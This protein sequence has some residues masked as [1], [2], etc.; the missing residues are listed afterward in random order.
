MP[1]GKPAGVTCVNLDPQTH[2]CTIWG[3]EKYPEVCR[4]FTATREFCGLSRTQALEALT[5]LEQQTS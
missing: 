2:E 3:T 4:R 1:N 5:V